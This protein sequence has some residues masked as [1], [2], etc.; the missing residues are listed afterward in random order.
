MENEKK[1]SARYPCES[2]EKCLVYISE[3]EKLNK[4]NCTLEDLSKIVGS[5]PK[6]NLIKTKISTLRQ[7]GLL[8]GQKDMLHPTELAKDYFLT[9][10]EIKQREY[11]MIAFKNV[12]LYNKIMEKF[13]ST[14]L[15]E[16]DEL[17]QILLE[18]E[19]GLTKA[20][21]NL[22]AKIFW[23]NIADLGIIEDNSGVLE[24]KTDVNDGCQ[25]PGKEQEEKRGQV[26]QM[27]NAAAVYTDN[28]VFK[29]PLYSGKTVKMEIPGEFTEEDLE[30]VKFLISKLTIK[31][32]DNL[33]TK[34][35]HT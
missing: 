14:A 20:T 3:V 30:F 25:E 8:D 4:E 21:H 2:L 32:I 9:P 26:K 18:P 24:K 35:S 15:P 34:T 7:Y 5:R 19:F 1:K 12:P 28:C 33:F 13:K 23:E 27:S 22:A 11:K 16:I 29:I 10:D 17:A 31:D 6:S